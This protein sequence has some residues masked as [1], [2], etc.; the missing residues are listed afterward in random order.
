[1]EPITTFEGT[2]TDENII[3]SSA[4]DGLSPLLETSINSI[5]GFPSYMIIGILSILLLIGIYYLGKRENIQK[6]YTILLP[7]LFVFIPIFI[8]GMIDIIGINIEASRFRLMIAPIFAIVISIGCFI[9]FQT[10]QSN[11][12]K[13]LPQIIIYSLCFIAIALSPTYTIPTDANVY[14]NTENQ[15]ENYFNE[16]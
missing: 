9:V 12:R 11:K 4:I 6:Q 10:L 7:I 14:V 13:K 8:E 3:I 5:P 16:N 2:I 15:E 1:M